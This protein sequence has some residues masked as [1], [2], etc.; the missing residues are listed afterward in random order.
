VVFVCVVSVCVVSV[1]VVSVVCVESVADPSDDEV[2]V[3]DA[4][5][6]FEDVSAGLELEGFE[7]VC[8]GFDRSDC[9]CFEFVCFDGGDDSDEV[10]DESELGVSAEAG[11]G[12]LTMAAPTP[13]ATANPPTRPT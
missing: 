5:V 1:F 12:P 11:P 8:L 3:P 13:S 6:E 10:F 4:P 7:F 2:G 9:V